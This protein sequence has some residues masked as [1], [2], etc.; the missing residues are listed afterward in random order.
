MVIT[1]CLRLKTIC[2]LNNIDLKHHRAGVESKATAELILQAFKI[3]GIS[4]LD[5]FP[6]KLKTTIGQ[7]YDGGYRPSETKR[8][9]HA[10]G[11]IK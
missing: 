3:A 1:S 11:F 5:D 8:V 9:Y 4:S 10:K 7:L 2:K 6:K